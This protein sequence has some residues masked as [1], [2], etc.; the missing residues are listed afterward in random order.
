MGFTI[1]GNM[2][3]KVKVFDVVNITVLILFAIACLFP[4]L[5]EILISFSSKVD[6]YQSTFLVIPQ[7]FTF[8]NYKFIF[9]QNTIGNALAVS[10][11]ITVVGVCFN[12]TLTIIGAYAL[13]RT[14]MF[15]GRVFFLFV[16]F[17]MFFGGGLIPFYI[18]VRNLG[19]MQN[20][21]I[22]IFS[23]IIP[24]GIS[25]FNMI[26][27]RN[28]FRAV[29]DEIIESCSMD[30]ASQ[31]RIMLQFV[32]PLSKAGIA[33][34]ALFYAVE[35]WNDWYWP[36]LFIINPDYQPLSLALRNALSSNVAGDSVTGGVDATITFA[37]G[38]NAATIVIAIL[39]IVAVY[40]FV[41]KYFVR[42]VMLGSVKG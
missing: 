31:I 14:D 42:G 27:L 28:F 19:L 30:G 24:F 39:P 18:V 23:V 10:L 34:V 25:G 33:T 15:L 6:F 7:N 35:R 2:K 1:E 9:I 36:M 26:I 3:R 11:F 13:S 41:Q 5:Y 32:V 21:F 40:P 16:L 38:Q 22:S 20:N 12:M 29:P 4:F 17:T 8:E 37:E